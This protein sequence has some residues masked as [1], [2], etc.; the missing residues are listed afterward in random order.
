[1][2]LAT[3]ADLKTYLGIT[4]AAVDTE[5]T[6]LLNMASQVAEQ[7]VERTL[8]SGARTERRSGKGGNVLYLKNYPITAVS[9]LTIDGTTYTASDGTTTGYLINDDGMSLTLIGACFNVGVKN[10]VVNYTAGYTTIPDDVQHSVI[11]IAAQAY[12]EKDWIGFSAK[13]LAGESVTFTRGFIPDSAKAVLGL[14][15]RMHHCD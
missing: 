5:L 4:T 6:R 8:S 7:H 2:P 13:T 10:I 14:Y 9:L 12:R 15:Q 1:M 11:E 3:L